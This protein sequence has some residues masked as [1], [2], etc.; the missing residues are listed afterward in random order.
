MNKYLIEILKIKLSVIL[1]G[2]GALM[3]PNK[4]TGKIV[5]NQ[6]LKFDD[7]ILADYISDKEGIDKT[8]AKNMISKFIREIESVIGKGDTYD[9]FQFGKISKNEKGDLNFE[10]DPY[11]LKEQKN[12]IA[13]TQKDD[14]PA[15][16]FVPS[17]KEK[18][19]VPKKEEVKPVVK[20]VEKGEDKETKNT[21]VPP[22]VTDV[23]KKIVDKV[24]S[25]SKVAKED[26]TDAKK[27][28]KAL[29][30]K[31]KLKTKELAA[32]SKKDAKAIENQKK[33]DAKAL[34]NKK[35]EEAKIAT[36]KAKKEKATAKKNKTVELDKNGK[37]V[38]KK[39]RKLIPLILLL[40]FV[41]GGCFAGYKY[42]DK[43]KEMIGYGKVSEHQN[44]ETAEEHAEHSDTELADE[45]TDEIIEE[46]DTMFV[47]E[48]IVDEDLVEEV[49]E[50]VPVE[51]HSVS[52][53]I[54]GNYHIIGGG[55]SEKSN[56]TRYADK[57]NGTVLGRFDN[58]YLVALKSYDSREA[59]KSDL[60]NVQSISSSAWIFKYSK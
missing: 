12:A 46:T 39:K 22:V 27:E 44:G 29:E 2:F 30:A 49:E 41:G 7:G 48:A 50:I 21:Y 4:K 31:K 16:E 15:N 55:F 26:T 35:K 38:K 11:L 5:I 8:E 56:A 3:I 53:S 19:E 45:S 32:K 9:I 60:S 24:K 33:K 34:T 52:T 58:L 57:N 17:A 13:S 47:D 14:K 54:N 43:I 59:A 25:P 1:P 37:P 28:A 42:Q 40:L 51:N 36:A 23:K 18:K 20:K 6:L 10:M